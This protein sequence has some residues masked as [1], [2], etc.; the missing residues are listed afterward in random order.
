MEN[1]KN[2][3]SN[4][5]SELLACSLSQNVKPGQS[6]CVALSGG[7]DSVTLLHAMVGATKSLKSTSLS[8]IHVNHGLSAQAGH[9]E[10]FCTHL[11]EQLGLPLSVRYVQVVA[12]GNG[13]E[14]AARKAR[15]AELEQI[16]CD[17]IVL[18]H[19]RGDQ[20][21]TV[22]LN[23]LRGTG[24]HGAAAMP[25]VRGR[26]LRP[27][28][29][30]PPSQ[31]LEYADR[32]RLTWI[33]DES[34]ADIRYSRNFIRHE[35]IPLLSKLFPQASNS[36]ARAA[37]SFSIAASLLDEIASEDMGSGKA[38]EVSRLAALSP[39]RAANLLAY[40]LRSY[41]LQIPG[42]SMLCELLRQLKTAG[43]DRQICFVVGKHTI[44]RYRGCVCITESSAQV[45]VDQVRWTDEAV[46]PWGR[47]H[48]R[49]RRTLGSGI[50]MGM[51]KNSSVRFSLRNG[52]E[53]M[54][55]RTSGP[56]RPLKDWLREAGVPPWI[57]NNLP[58]MYAGDDLVW[59][60]AVGIAAKYRCN[61]DSE[62]VLIEFD[63]LTW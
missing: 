56:S 52:G 36:L 5:L 9:W 40:F 50:D 19:H 2:S 30:V 20:A 51:L 39:Q 24:L 60:P 28:L 46:L 34:N 22:L 33:T 12:Q 26:F 15:Y 29:D 31:I 54:Q 53:L 32:H 11:C 35:A 48:I 3:P 13:L 27:F 42:K 10:E 43:H 57:R 4:D 47:N 16:D 58:V 14:A 17:W 7:M 55:L 21:E 62:G 63:G 25:L 8:V 61:P 44:R 1:S 23:I 38:L 59:V 41:G 45:A 6:L 49:T 37:D 18:G